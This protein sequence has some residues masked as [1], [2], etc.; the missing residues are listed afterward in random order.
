MTS[1][2]SAPAHQET[3][4]ET[5]TTIT[6]VS[7][8]LK[9]RAESVINDKT[10]DLQWRTIIRYALEINDPSLTDFVQR[11]EAGENITATFESL[12]TLEANEDNSTLRKIEAL[13]EIIC[14]AGNEPT[15]ALFILMET[16]ES[17]ARPK[18]FTSRAKHVAFSRCG[19]L[20]VYEMVNAQIAMVEREL[21]A[22]NTLRS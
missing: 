18:V 16:V 3:P 14:R 6:T 8:E 5:E 7:D 17:S 4:H 20:Q 9:H 21:L 11:A 13:T 19:E 10:I 12:G 22:T 15:A 2:S 1:H